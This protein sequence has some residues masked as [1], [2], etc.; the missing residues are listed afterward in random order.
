MAAKNLGQL[1]KEIVEKNFLEE[2]PDIPLEQKVVV[3]KEMP[4]MESIVFSNYRDPGVALSFHYASATHPLGRYTLSHGQK[5]N[6]PAEIV[7]HLHGDIEYDLHSCHEP[8]HGI[9]KNL[10]GRNQSYI[11][12]WKQLY[13]CKPCRA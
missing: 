8:I 3:A 12:D 9:K 4:K 11:Q 6:L 5:Y 10:E 7:N 1:G 13:Q 2:T